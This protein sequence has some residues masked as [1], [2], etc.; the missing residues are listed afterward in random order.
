VNEQRSSQ[1]LFSQERRDLRARQ[2]GHLIVTLNGKRCV[3]PLRGGSREIGRG[4]WLAI[5][6][7]LDIRE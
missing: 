6:K 3:L 4:L 7:Q 5:L 2:G 1:A